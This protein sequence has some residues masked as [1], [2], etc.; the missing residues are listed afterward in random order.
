MAVKELKTLSYSGRLMPRAYAVLQA[1]GSGGVWDTYTV[2]ISL[3]MRGEYRPRAKEL[4][5]TRNLTQAL[6]QFEHACEYI[7]SMADGPRKQM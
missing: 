5:V 4:C 1:S 6:Q 2:L 3:K 7:K